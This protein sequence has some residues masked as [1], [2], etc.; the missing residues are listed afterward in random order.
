MSLT[1]LTN[2]VQ[3]LDFGKTGHFILVEKTG[4]ILSNP[5]DSNSVFKMVGEIEE[6]GLAALASGKDGISTFQYRG[7][8]MLGNVL[9]GYNGYKILAVAEAGEIYAPVWTAIGKVVLIGSAV[10]FTLLVL[11]WFLAR[12]VGEPLRFLVRVSEEVM[13][14]NYKAMPEHLNFSGEFIFL[15]KSMSKIIAE[16]KNKIS[17]SENALEAITTPTSVIGTDKTML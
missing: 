17:F 7:K 2:L 5:I 6:P 11:A 13:K 4:R 12:S 9:T 15:A 16:I 1:S 3:S 14:G 10:F 8:K